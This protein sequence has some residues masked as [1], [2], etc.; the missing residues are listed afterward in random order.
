LPV[1]SGTHPAVLNLN[2]IIMSLKTVVL[3]GAI[4]AIIAGIGGMLFCL[5]YLWSA[6]LPDLIGA[7]FPF[8]GGAI[9][10][11]GG[12]IS[13]ALVLRNFKDVKVTAKEESF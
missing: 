11:S 1:F 6:R 3:F 10:A 2:N 13:L 4:A 12:L 5:P 9:L 8:V 7:G